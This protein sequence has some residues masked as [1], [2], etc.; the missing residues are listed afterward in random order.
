MQTDD[1]NSQW[2]RLRRVVKIAGRL[3]LRRWFNILCFPSI[4]SLCTIYW[5]SSSSKIC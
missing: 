3:F 4:R 5:S 2:L 1:G